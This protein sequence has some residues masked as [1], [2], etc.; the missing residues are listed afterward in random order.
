MKKPQTVR[1]YEYKND[2]LY[3][4]IRQAPDLGPRSYLYCCGINISR[5]DPLCW[6]KAGICSNPAFKGLQLLR[7]D[8]SAFAR[9]IDVQ[10]KNAE[11]IPCGPM[12]PRGNGWYRENALVIEG[13]D[14]KAIQQILEFSVRDLVQTVL[15]V[16]APDAKLP[17]KLPNPPALQKWLESFSVKDYMAAAPPPIA[18]LRDQK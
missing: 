8:V 16:C 4:I 9:K 12:A 15:T 5:F 18:R 10:A 13:A 14:P 7:A 11:H 17:T 1:S 3:I 6:G 2:F